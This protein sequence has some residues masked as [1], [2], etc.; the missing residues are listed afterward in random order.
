MVPESAATSCFFC[1]DERAQLAAAREAYHA[2]LVAGPTELRA[3]SRVRKRAAHL[4]RLLA[5]H[6]CDLPRA[7]PPSPRQPVP[8]PERVT[9]SAV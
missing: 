6:V 7:A 5:R 4:E 9:A 2:L 1:E 8:E 3:A